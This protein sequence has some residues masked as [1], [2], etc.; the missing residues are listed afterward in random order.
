MAVPTSRLARPAPFQ[1]NPFVLAPTAANLEFLFAFVKLLVESGAYRMTDTDERDAFE[2]IRSLY[3]LAPELRTLDTLCKTLPRH[4]SNHLKRWTRGEQYPLFDN[5]TDTVTFSTFQCVDFEGMER[6]GVVLEALL[7]YLLHRAN[8]VILDEAFATTWKVFIV[9]EAWRFFKHAATRA[10]IVQAL[11][12]WRKKNA[13][14]I[15]AT[16]SME[17]LDL[18]VL[19]PVADACPTK[20][21]LANPNIDAAV[22]SDL[23][24]LTPTEQDKVKHLVPKK[25]FLLKRDALAKVLTLNV[26]PESYWL[27]TTNPFEAKRRQDL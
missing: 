5:P 13:S 21:L 15:L 3:V 24:G 16:Q 12:T 20:F 26:D 19:R 27:F 17:D 22:Y 23:L 7:F 2:A 8:D 18:E 1:I 11:K 14:M 10:Y 9:D 4:I 6:A 25:Q